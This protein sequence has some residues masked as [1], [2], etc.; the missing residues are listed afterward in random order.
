MDLLVQVVEIRGK[1]PVYKV[2]DSFKLE[3]GYRLVSEKPVCMHALAALMPFYNA[4]RVSSAE[5]WG[6]AGK[7][8]KDRAYVQC[9]DAQPYTDGG[10]AFF[11]ISRVDEG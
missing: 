5:R 9:P 8:N 1:C 3:G 7:D 4:L 11:E 10:T 6:L 2:G